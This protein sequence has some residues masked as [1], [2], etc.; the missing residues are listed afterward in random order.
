MRQDENAAVGETAAATAR[1]WVCCARLPYGRGEKAAVSL[2]SP[3]HIAS[4]VV[5]SASPSARGGL[6]YIQVFIENKTVDSAAFVM[7]TM[8]A[9]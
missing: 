7:F 8:L 2:A 4:V 6:L 9:C 3:A 5:A 1:G